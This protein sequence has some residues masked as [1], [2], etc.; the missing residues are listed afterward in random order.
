MHLYYIFYQ[1][2]IYFY[3]YK[4]PEK[5]LPR[6]FP[7]YTLSKQ[8]AKLIPYRDTGERKITVSSDVANKSFVEEKSILTIIG[9]LTT[10]SISNESKW[11]F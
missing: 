10:N 5:T 1:V 9:D 8:F 2:P 11:L 3:K 7:Q 6:K 4:A